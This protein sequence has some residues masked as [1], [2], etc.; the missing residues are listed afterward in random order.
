MFTLVL[1]ITAGINFAA[2]ADQY[3]QDRYSFNPAMVSVP[4]FQNLKACNEAY[5]PLYNMIAANTGIGLA[6]IA[7][8]CVRA[9]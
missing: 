5:T 4:G 7:Y 1:F 2:P 6:S 3:P 9:E 8:V